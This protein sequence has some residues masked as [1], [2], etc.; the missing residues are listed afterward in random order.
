LG[1]GTRPEL[2]AAI[3]SELLPLM[4]IQIAV[5]LIDAYVK[6]DEKLRYD[7]GHRLQ[8]LLP[9]RW[10]DDLPWYQ[11]LRYLLTQSSSYNV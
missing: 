5:D 6:G 9:H 2:R 11:S 7:M 10:R 3:D 8:S 1:G 4:S